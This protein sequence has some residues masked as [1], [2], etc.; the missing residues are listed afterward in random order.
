[1]FL[2]NY[3]KAEWEISEY[4][5]G[6]QNADGFFPRGPVSNH[7]ATT[8]NTLATAQQSSNNCTNCT[9]ATESYDDLA[10][11]W[12]VLHKLGPL[13]DENLFDGYLLSRSTPS[14]HLLTCLITGYKP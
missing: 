1:M 9:L 4:H 3:K 8:K 11:W 14:M 12:Q 6:V 10:S 7:L 2:R 5:P 13:I